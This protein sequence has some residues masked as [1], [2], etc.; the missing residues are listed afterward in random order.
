MFKLTDS[1]V[2]DIIFAMENQNDFAFIN[3]ETGE[4]SYPDE[5][6]LGDT[7]EFTV[8]EAPVGLASLP[9]WSS[10]DGF[11]TMEDFVA[12]LEDYEAK[13]SLRAIL[14]RRRGVFRSFKEAIKSFPEAEIAFYRYKDER[15]KAR[16]ADW[17]AALGEERREDSGNLARVGESFPEG[18]LGL[19]GE[20]V[21]YD[22]QELNPKKAIN[23][24]DG[25][26]EEIV[27]SDVSLTME[28][29]RP[30]LARLRGEILSAR[31]V[32]C[33]AAKIRGANEIT[34][35]CVVY[36][37]PDKETPEILVLFME[38][39]PGFPSATVLSAFL[40]FIRGLAKGVILQGWPGMET[41]YFANEAQSELSIPWLILK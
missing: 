26:M 41:K 1:V 10:S 23:S 19:E 38:A 7:E 18:A 34:G 15:M 11:S 39:L 32:K 9:D 28:L 24:I 13:N 2:S 14:E 40:Q 37:D 27:A 17:Y 35:L 21:R 12:T 3:I 20:D 31:G 33:F 36:I 4:V 8:E 5:A 29:R 16:I 6:T 25:I 22:I 30:F